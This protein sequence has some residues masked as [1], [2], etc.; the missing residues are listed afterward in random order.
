MA[1][2][3][4]KKG[5]VISRR[6]FLKVSGVASGM[7]AGMAAVSSK[8][9]V[10]KALALADKEIAGVSSET[11]I[12]SGVCRGNCASGCFLNVHVRDGKVVQ[13][14]MRDMPD[15]QYNRICVKG[16]THMQRI[17]HPQRLKYPMK[18]VGKR[19]EGKFEKITWEEAISTIADKYK[20]YGKE[21]FAMSWGSGSYGSLGGQALGC[22]TNR[23]LNAAGCAYIPL[24]VDAAHGYAAGYTVGHGMNFTL[25]EPK[26]LHNAKTILIWGANPVISQPHVMHFIM[27]AKE[28]G[29][30]IIVI[31]PIQNITASKADM[32]V[33]VRPGTDGALALAMM[34]IVVREGWIDLEFMKRA[35]V[36]PLLVKDS[37][38]M[39]LRLSDTKTLAEDEADGFIVRDAEGNFGLASEI[40]DPVV[41]G[42]FTYEDIA[43]TT[44]YTLLLGKIAEYP[45]QKAAEICN[46]SVEQI[47]ELA[48]IYATN[49]PATIYN[50]FGIDHYINAHYNIFAM[51]ALAM[52]TGNM[53][54][55][56]TG[57]G[58][59]EVI[60]FY[61]NI[62][63]TLY[64]EGATGPSITLPLPEMNKVM[65]EH[66]S[67]SKEID[68]KGAFFTH[69]NH[70]GNGAQR[71]STID[72][73][74]KLEFVAVADMNMNETARYADILLPV[75]HWF[76]VKDI[77]SCYGT[78][79][80][81]LLQ[82]Q[83][84]QPLYE[85]KAD[86]EITKLL[87]EKMGV[88]AAFQF[89]E[90][91]Y[92]D[93]WLDTDFARSM[94]L[95]R[96]ELEEKKAIK[97]LPGENFVFA[98]GGVFSTPTGRA[99]FYN[100]TPAPNSNYDARFWNKEV[101]VELERLPTW[102]PP[103][104]AWHENSL[105]D[106][107]PY[108]LISEHVKFR[109]HSQWWDVPTLLELDPEP[110]AKFN[111]DDAAKY[112]IETGDKVKLFNDRGY[113][114]MHAAIHGGVQPGV[115]VAPKG[116]EEGQ[117]IDGHFSDLTTHDMNPLC[118]N[119]GYFDVLVGVEKL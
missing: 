54:K 69:I 25:N 13:T 119:Q 8:K 35:T 36:A 90:D 91:E 83:A 84:V 67:G 49:G 56:G 12:Y 96:Q 86:F 105:H 42:N 93:L 10:L 59:G 17:Y 37:D 78:H 31:D 97:C 101:D 18:R 76:E 65:D 73:M 94:G 61:C 107:Y 39:Y 33:P 81:L 19:G 29:A 108:I 82:E 9:P 46:I 68:L 43:V 113:V 6:D 57:C 15:T 7:V 45:P 100:E 40:A 72:W 85:C 104:E 11:Q 71:K 115:I 74:N 79:P 44:T 5:D 23:L 111:A 95:T 88:G 103:Y 14:S 2:V 112:G 20:E 117:F 48:R 53:T 34:N 32:F 62:M 16:L 66:M 116:W 3:T 118:A 102:I 87:A 58:M 109:T 63:G 28:M 26:D 92:I 50:Y 75:A 89:T 51:Y 47:E 52:I 55:P 80:Y 70:L 77:F 38:G 114:V 30:K 106:K 99:Q 64:P 60:P 41:E 1:D 27:E 22:P 110:I 21:G 4:Q 98:E 24:T